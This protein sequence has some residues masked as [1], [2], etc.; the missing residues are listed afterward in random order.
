MVGGGVGLA[1]IAVVAVMMMNKG[2]DGGTEDLKLPVNGST[3]ASAAVTAAAMTAVQWDSA[4][5]KLDTLTDMLGTANATSA[6]L[7]LSKLD[8]LRTQAAS[9]TAR[10]ARVVFLTAR[11]HFVL[12]ENAT[13]DA[14][15]QRE[16]RTGCALLMS[17]EGLG[18]RGG[19]AS[20]FS[21]F[22]KGDTK[23]KLPALCP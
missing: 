12:S 7:A 5:A 9:D 17:N 20:Q 22:L 3:G 14:E 1:A 23:A 19:L 16:L 4:F 10:K 2:K 18:A 21:F 6:T 15:K 13:D 11:A 8:S